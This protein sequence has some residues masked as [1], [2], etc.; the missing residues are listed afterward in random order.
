MNFDCR[1]ARRR[2]HRR[3]YGEPMPGRVLADRLGEHIHAACVRWGSRAYPNELLVA[4]WGGDEYDRISP[5]SRISSSRSS[6]SSG[7]SKAAI[8]ETEETFDM[9]PTRTLDVRYPD[10][11]RQKKGYRSRR[12]KVGDGDELVGG[13][14]HERKIMDPAIDRDAGFQLYVVDPSGTARRHR[15]AS[16]GRGSARARE[17]LRLRSSPFSADLFYV[18]EGEGDC[19]EAE[20]GNEEQTEDR[21]ERSKL[22]RRGHLLLSEMTCAEAARAIVEEVKRAKE[23][24]KGE[25][26][27]GMGHG[28]ESLPEIAW[29]SMAAEEE[30]KESKEGNRNPCC[31]VHY[32][33]VEEFFEE[34]ET[35]EAGKGDGIGSEDGENKC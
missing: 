12:M 15:A 16:S 9:L 5:S 17:W 6:S 23:D 19:E 10:E 26:G 13:L 3:E 11:M 32:R 31:F 24:G 25:V 4:C 30:G 18:G 7:E 8:R 20:G 27:A 21:D 29:L 28:V 1:Y 33:S 35:K 2:S 14:H 34:I 22:G